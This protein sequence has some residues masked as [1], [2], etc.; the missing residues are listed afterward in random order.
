MTNQ[1][2]NPIAAIREFDF[3][4]PVVNVGSNPA[5][6]VIV[7]GEGVMPFH[8]SF[9]RE[10]GSFSI[11]P[12]APEAEIKLEGKLLHAASGSLSENQRIEI[13]D[14]SLYLQKGITPSGFHLTI[15]KSTGGQIDAPLE[16]G[17]LDGDP[18]IL[19]NLLNQQNIIE[20]EQCAVYEFEVVNG[21]RYVASFQV[22]IQGVPNEWVQ[23]TPR[24]V[25]LNEGQ[26]ATVRASITPPREPSSMAGTHALNIVVT[27]PNYP[28]QRSVTPIDLTIQPYYEF[29]ASNLTPRQQH[30]RWSEHSNIVHLPIYN[31]S[32]CT[33]DFTVMAL[34]DENGCAF[35]FEVG[36]GVRHTR[37]TTVSISAGETCNLPI[38]ITPNRQPVISIRNKH[39]HYTTT[40]QVTG[41]AVSPQTLSGTVISHPLLGW[42]AVLLS[43]LLI[44]VGLF[45]LVQPRINSFQVAASKDVIELGDSTNLEWSVSPFAIR[46]SI[47]NIDKEITRSMN[48]IAVAP[49]QSTTYEMVAGNWISGLL[50]MDYTKKVTVLVVPPS[51]NIAVF[52]VD[53][54]KVDQGNPVKIRWSV[55]DTDK[56]LLTIDEVVYELTAEEFSG[57]RSVV[58]EKDSIVTLEASNLSGSELRSYYID[59]VPPNIEIVKYTV[60]VRPESSTTSLIQ[61]TPSLAFSDL[62]PRQTGLAALPSVSNRAGLSA[63]DADFSQKFVE[64][65][66][67]DTSDTGYKVVFYQP[68]RELAKGEQ[69]MLEWEVEGVEKLSIAPFT[70]ELP[71]SGKQPYF[72]QESMNFVLTA[73]NGELEKLFMLP[74]NVFDGEPPTAPKVDFFKAVPVKM[75]GPGSVQFSWSV[76]GEWT[77]IQL[78]KGTDKGEEVVADW[79]NPQGFK[80]VT[81]SESGTF[82]LKAWNGELS[83]AQ[84]VDITVDPA[85]KKINLNINDVYTDAGRFMVGRSVIVTVGFTNIPVDSPKP[86]G[87]VT[88]TDGYSTCTI[89]LPALSCE[90]TFITPGEKKITA[91]Y[92]GDTVYLQD[93]S[94]PYSQTILVES[95]EVELIPRYYV[96]GTDTVISDITSTSNNLNLDTGLRI[97]VEVRPKNINVPD[98]NLSK[99][100]VSICDQDASGAIVEG[101]C[102]F[103]ADGTAV[104]ATETDSLGRQAG[105]FYVDVSI[106]SFTQPGTHLFLFDYS[107][108]EG[109]I[110][111][112]SFEQP[113]VPIGKVHFHLS[114][115]ICDTDP[116]A[117]AY[118]KLGSADPSTSDKITFAFHTT[119]DEDIP[120]TLPEP[121]AADFTFTPMGE[122]GISATPLAC[123]I[124]KLNGVYKMVCETN[125]MTS[126]GNTWTVNY[127]FDNDSSDSYLMDTSTGSFSMDVLNTTS[128][129]ITD[130]G[131]LTVGQT[132]QLTGTGGI[133]SVKDQATSS[134]LS[135]PLVI[136]D[137]SGA[138]LTSFGCSST[139]NCSESDGKITILNSTSNSSIFV[140]K[141][142]KVDL[143]VTYE[144]DGTN[145]VGSSSNQTL[146]VSQLGGITSTWKSQ[147]GDWPNELIVNAPLTARIELDVTTPG[148]SE[149]VLVGRKMLLKM[150][151]QTAIE[152]CSLNAPGTGTAGEYLVTITSFTTG[153][154]ADFTLTCGNSNIVLPFDAYMEIGFVTNGEDTEGDD[155]A[156]SATADIDEEVRIKANDSAILET[157][158]QLTPVTSTTPNMTGSDS[159]V[160]TFLAGEKYQ[161]QFKLRTIYGHYN[162]FFD[163]YQSATQIINDYLNHDNSV[164]ISFPPAVE[165]A[166]DWEKSTCGIKNDI[167]V[168]L[169]QAV[170]I[171]QVEVNSSDI[172]NWG[173]V[174]FNLTNKYP[175]Y[176]V[177][178]KEVSLNQNTTFSFISHNEFYKASSSYNTTGVAKQNVNMTF[179]PVSPFTGLIGNPQYIK[180]NLSSSTNTDTT[181]PPIKPD[182]T[183]FDTQF[184][185]TTSCGSISDKKINSTSQAQFTLSSSTECISQTVTI[186]YLQNDY[187]NR[188][189]DQIFTFTFNKHASSAILQYYNASWGNTFPFSTTTSAIQNTDYKFRVKVVDSDGHTTIPTGTVRIKIDRTATY[190]IKKAN[191]GN[192]SAGTD[193]YYVLDLDNTGY[194]E[195][196]INFSSTAS[197]IKLLYEYPGSDYFR[198]DTDGASVPFN[199]V[200]PAP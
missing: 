153:P 100:S 177:F 130:P 59:V 91:S 140:K 149:N 138:G 124:L 188:L 183:S 13:G 120:T 81:V 139:E 116:I 196:T 90:L 135:V 131:R 172:W 35:D 62:T 175:C 111:P 80:K 51:P 19:V 79:I 114:S 94:D 115:E 77:H 128:V 141:A 93:D 4:Q 113:N 7:T 85:L 20:V 54:T 161:L 83:T 29:M 193:G 99:V 70:Q 154:V 68:D 143:T 133:V 132:V 189:D 40:T 163:D 160:L 47:S 104:A 63:S 30:I 3:D 108:Q 71:A 144:G 56:L 105:K 127:S 5:N 65:V 158:L 157:T 61:D 169:D 53:K 52:D 28:R 195:F 123:S 119:R 117:S 180:I 136:S 102:Q 155:F 46:L 32:N 110:N 192:I 185:V 122:S 88:V 151:N 86:T 126:A 187:F 24:F 48:H 67:D 118:C 194:A 142:G 36:E 9:L 21:G 98:D 10:N 107:H 38:E 39:Y 182:V 178:N 73:K 109:A 171:V 42:L 34:D 16:P 60:W 129:L 166:I 168:K 78:A 181:L 15:H 37:Q 44:V 95:A 96:L 75:T 66:A 137:S 103:I 17:R 89:N 92:E 26:R 64:L 23:I 8:A 106:F 33:A 55:T 49:G 174:N 11:I 76:S 170:D 2:M 31:N 43:I 1:T 150:K 147:T 200:A 25:N 145:Y 152:A 121:D 164:V 41:Q 50:G 22:S 12:M 27:S 190:T 173:H 57:E 97:I 69:V 58:M 125:D 179:D 148:I 159:S 112:S 82:L 134:T 156:F 14:Y 186:D 197:N 199:V 198:S 18:S 84:P 87:K 162:L 165:N 72:P 45:F 184:A 167:R 191:G 6:D 146:M 74:V 101:T 176:L